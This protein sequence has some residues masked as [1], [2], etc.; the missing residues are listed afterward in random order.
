ML[1][2]IIL[3]STAALNCVMVVRATHRLVLDMAKKQ[4]RSA[5][6]VVDRLS[7]VG[8]LIAAVAVAIA[9]IAQARGWMRGPVRDVVLGVLVLYLIGA[10]VYW[11]FGGKRRLIAVLR[12]RATGDEPGA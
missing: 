11:W 7:L 5:E 1:L 3:Y 6:E 10:P 8:Q 9:A 4:P 2:S 12:A